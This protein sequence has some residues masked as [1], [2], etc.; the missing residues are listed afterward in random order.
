VSLTRRAFCGATL[1]APAMTYAKESEPMLTDLAR[2]AAIYLSPVYEMYRTRWN[3]TTDEANPYRQ[4]LNRF[5][6]SPRLADDKSRAVTTPNNDTLY[7]SA[8][9]DLS[10]EPL[11]L[12]VPDMGDRYYSFAFMSLFTDNFAYVCRRLHGRHP[13]PR[14]IVGPTWKGDVARGVELVRAP[15]NSVWLLGRIL[16]D[17]AEDL[18]AVRA[19]QAA[20][21]LETPDMRNERRIVEMQELMRQ[22]TV[23]PP[24]SVADWPAPNR[25]NPFDLFDVGLQALGES[26]IQP[27]D[28]DMLETLAP[29]KLRPGHKFDARA[30]GEGE[31]RAIEA[32]IAVARQD[33]L[34][35]GG[36]YGHVRNGWRFPA[37]DLG[38]FGDDDLYRAL[39]ALTGLGA[40]ELAEATY[41]SCGSDEAGKPL[42][43]A[44]RYVLR[45]DSGQLPPVKA[46]WS[47]SMYET[48]PEGRAFFTANSIGRYAIGDRTRGLKRGADGSL[49][50]LIQHERPAEGQ[51]TNWLPAPSGPMRLVLRAYEPADALLDGRYDMPPVRRLS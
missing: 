21:L 15:T 26:P 28:R 32:G 42:D 27:R 36:R 30:F 33:V 29:L 34:A 31:R 50:I 16:V 12:T 48:T 17:G 13:L 1:L 39:V 20:T 43:G 49:D 11:F 41:L 3:A 44:N 22:R 5:L 35:A 4:K 45:F 18:P 8:W 9:L 7:S 14:M 38:N 47:L 46:F 19:R 23:L 24:E 40:L 2:R 37:R 10:A 25:N 6:H 51:E